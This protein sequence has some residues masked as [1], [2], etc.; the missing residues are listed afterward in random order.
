MAKYLI[1]HI[2]HTDKWKAHVIWWNPY[3]RGYT[4]CI[5][6]AGQYDEE[7]AKSICREGVCIA[8][9]KEDVQAL[10]K[11]TP[12]FLQQG[13]GLVR[14]YDGGEH[15]VV[16]NSKAS[17]EHIMQHRIALG[18]TEKPTPTPPSKSRVAYLPEPQHTKDQA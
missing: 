13:G 12:Y 6:K 18:K 7:E 3:S 16:P 1:A 11:P 17:W 5:E 2:G 9:K 4:V 10:A 15:I 8:I 14:M